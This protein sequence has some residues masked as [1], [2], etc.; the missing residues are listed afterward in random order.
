[1]KKIDLGTLAFGAAGASIVLSLM[2]WML[3]GSPPT[4]GRYLRMKPPE[5]PPEVNQET[6]AALERLTPVLDQLGRSGEIA[7]ISP[8]VHLRGLGLRQPEKR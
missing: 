7:I 5:K 3:G 8:E 4:Q 6:M 2:L 1:M